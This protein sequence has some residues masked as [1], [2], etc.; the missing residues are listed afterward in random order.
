MGFL[1]C[2]CVVVGLMLGGAVVYVGWC[3]DCPASLCLLCWF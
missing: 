1:V 3:W 2:F